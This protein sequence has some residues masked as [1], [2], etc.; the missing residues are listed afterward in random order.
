MKTLANS[1]D[2]DALWDYMDPFGSE[3]RF[4]AALSQ[5][6][7]GCSMKQSNSSVTITTYH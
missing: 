6:H 1:E 2:I 5:L 7:L 3:L 4:D